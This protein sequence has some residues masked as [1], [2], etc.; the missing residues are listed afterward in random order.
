MEFF[1]L[2]RNT[3]KL[4]PIILNFNKALK[5]NKTMRITAIILLVLLGISAIFGGGAFIID[6]SG[7]LIQMP[8]SHLQHS[9][10]NNF[11]IP[12]LILFLFNGVSGIVIAILAI[13]NFRFYADL[14]M[15]QGSVQV[16][17]IIVQLMMIRSI[18]ILHYACF[19][20]GVLLIILG[21]K[22]HKEQKHLKK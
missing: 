17:W 2:H 8:I 13:R 16:V 18:S 15:L 9:P 20:I 11:L 19:S 1:Y 5:I 10:F 12:G 3:F 21:F 7:E 6:P 22:L 4:T 14:V